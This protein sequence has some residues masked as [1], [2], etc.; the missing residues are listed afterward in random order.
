MKKIGVMRQD[1]VD[2]QGV[3]YSKNRWLLVFDLRARKLI[4]PNDSGYE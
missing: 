2:N 1:I 3:H 4:L